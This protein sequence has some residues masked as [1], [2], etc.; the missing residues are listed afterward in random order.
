MEADP[1]VSVDSFTHTALWGNGERQEGVDQQTC[2][3]PNTTPLVWQYSQVPPQGSKS[4][5][6][7]WSLEFSEELV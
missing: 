6:D 4:V 5:L 1:W 2:D 3:V 7:D